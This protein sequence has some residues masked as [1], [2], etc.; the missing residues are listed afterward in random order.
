MNSVGN[1]RTEGP[2]PLMS[3][4]FNPIADQAI[5]VARI[6]DMLLNPG[7]E[8]TFQG[9][10]HTYPDIHLVHWAGAI[11]SIIISSLIVWSRAGSARI[12]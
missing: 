12:R 4:G 10:T 2:S 5:P 7:A 11:P 6:S 1:P 3:T 8:Y 9:Q